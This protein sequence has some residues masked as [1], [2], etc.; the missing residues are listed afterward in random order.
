[1]NQVGDILWIRLLVS[2]STDSAPFTRIRW[3]YDLLRCRGGEF[4]RSTRCHIHTT[5]C[6]NTWAEQ[7]SN[8]IDLPITFHYM[9]PVSMMFSYL[10]T[11]YKLYQF[12]KRT[13]GPNSPD[14][15]KLNCKNY[16]P[17]RYVSYPKIKYA[18][19]IRSLTFSAY[20]TLSTWAINHVLRLCW[21]FRRWWKSAP[22]KTTAICFCFY[23]YGYKVHIV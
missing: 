3:W 17:G 4:H 7:F 14:R 1:M 6:L 22:D 11:T 9:Y 10:S 19:L 18:W 23:R 20:S 13:S 15:S 21:A 5:R 12:K 8:R 16:V 2:P